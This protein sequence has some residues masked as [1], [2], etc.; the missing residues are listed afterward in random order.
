M[1]LGEQRREARD[2]D[3]LRQEAKLGVRIPNFGFVGEL[4]EC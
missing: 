1:R 2:C 3:V 4:M